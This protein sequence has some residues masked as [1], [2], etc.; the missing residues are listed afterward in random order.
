[1]HFKSAV[2]DKIVG[3]RH[4]FGT[5][6]EAVP[7][8]L[9]PDWSA[10]HP[11]WKQV[12]GIQFIEVTA[13]HQKCGETDALVTF[14]RGIPVAV[15]TADCVPVLLARKTGG[16]AAAIHAGWRGTFNGAVDEVSRFLISR[17]EKLSNWVAAV[18]PAIG[19]CC[20]E[21]SEELVEDFQK[22][23][24]GPLNEAT[25]N[26]G[27][28]LSRNLVSPTFRRLDLPAIHEAKL[29]LA[30]FSEIDVIRS[31]TVCSRSGNEPIFQSYRREKN[32]A[33]QYSGLV[34][35]S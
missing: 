21:V 22:K 10:A 4:G 8:S 9:E 5:R 28:P 33:R 20:F 14:E 26:Q 12:H 6:E 18:G 3:L 7:T 15:V 32:G 17:G 27:A 31:C 29:R 30:G 25:F 13:S 34:F 16:A 11:S 24:S 1:M 2:L 23:F 19:P 35:E